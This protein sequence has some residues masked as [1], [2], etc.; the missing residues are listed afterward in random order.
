MSFPALEAK[1]AELAA[2]NADLH[3]IFDEAGPDLDMSA[4]KS[5]HGSTADKVA[6]IQRKNARIDEVGQEVQDLRATAEIAAKSAAFRAEQKA[7]RNG[8]TEGGSEQS[9]RATEAKA[10]RGHKSLGDLFT[11]SVAYKG[12]QSGS[13]SPVAELDISL[14]TLFETGAGWEPETTRGPRFVDYVT[15]PIQVVDIVP[16]TTT[17]QVAITYMEETTFTNNAAEIAEGGLYPES[18]LGVEEKSSPV[19]KIGTWIPVTDEQLEDVSQARGYVNN[20][21]PFMVRQRL[22]SQ[23]LV[24]NGTAPNL[25]GLLNV[26]GIQTQAKGTD[27]TP[28]AAYKAMTKVM[29][30]ALANPNAFVFNPLDWS[31]IRLLR[32][33]D[34]IYIWGSP[35]EAGPARLWGLPVVLAQGLTENTA[36]VGDFQN[37]SELSTKRGLDMQISNSHDD[38]FVNGKQAIRADVRVALV[39]YRPAA[40]ATITGI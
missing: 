36:V 40:F 31:D 34:G 9:E 8:H 12:R 32:T 7:Q 13:N 14:K 1:Q 22:D 29:V 3:A 6:E 10:E 26:S 11:D 2:L 30:T 33:A 4:V 5:L 18:A 39:F 15:R 16:G 27:P 25:R 17:N 37:F 24:G 19:R 23:I 38:F 28:D 20:R 35:M 21:L